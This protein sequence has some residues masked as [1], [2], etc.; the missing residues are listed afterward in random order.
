MHDPRSSSD[1]LRLHVDLHVNN[2]SC[3]CRIIIVLIMSAW[4]TLTSAPATASDD[5]QLERVILLYRHGVRTPLPGEIQANEVTGKP[6]PTWSQAPSELTPHGAM[7]AR[8]MGAYDRER[9]TAEGLFPTKECPAS[10]RY[11]A[12]C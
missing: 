11:A 5:M 8:R 9:L 1:I 12:T 10:S 3:C 2:S 7:G 6:W 4:M